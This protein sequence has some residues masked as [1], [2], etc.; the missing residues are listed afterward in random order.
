MSF[1]EIRFA[2]W[3]WWP[4]KLLFL[5]PKAEVHDAE[6]PLKRN[7]PWNFVVVP[8]DAI[9]ITVKRR[10]C[11]LPPGFLDF[12]VKVGQE[13]ISFSCDELMVNVHRDGS[14]LAQI[15]LYKLLFTEC[16]RELKRIREGNCPFSFVLKVNLLAMSY[17]N[18]V[19]P[20]K[21][22]ISEY[23]IKASVPKVIL[24][25]LL[26]TPPYRGETV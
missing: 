13:I 11:S 2:G 10:S 26:L 7:P 21:V 14:F 24:H 1:T 5:L 18:Y 6:V 15:N 23:E 20:S 22:R 12:M 16:F 19:V 8:V 4:R 9:E 17:L 3:W 25:H